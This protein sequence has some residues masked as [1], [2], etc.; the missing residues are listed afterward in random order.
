[1]G[2]KT[3]PII[4]MVDTWQGEGPYTGY[5]V[6]LIRF[7]G[8]NLNC[9]WCDQS[10]AKSVDAAK[11]FTIQQIESELPKCW[12]HILLTGGEP[13]LYIDADLVT[14]LGRYQTRVCVLGGPTTPKILIETNG[15]LGINP[16]IRTSI[17]TEV[18]VSPK[19]GAS[20]GTLSYS[21]TPSWWLK[22]VVPG[23]WPSPKILAKHAMSLTERS[24]RVYLQPQWPLRWT[25]MK[26]V[27]EWAYAFGTITGYVPRLSLQS[28]KFVN[29]P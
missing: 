19:Y 17:N 10:D 26:L 14:M 25:S 11:R 22:Y 18:I 8:C 9:K 13:M 15:V 20:L 3:Y 12:C 27:K 21:A 24:D 5:P 4:D 2:E 6:F 29:N 16:S 7:A 28:H 23:D 1:M